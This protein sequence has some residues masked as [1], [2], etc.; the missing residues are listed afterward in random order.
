MPQNDFRAVVRVDLGTLAHSEVLDAAFFDV[1]ADLLNRHF[2]QW[3]QGFLDFGNCHTRFIGYAR[4]TCKNFLYFCALFCFYL[5]TRQFMGNT[6]V[7][8]NKV[9]LEVRMS[10]K[11]GKTTAFRQWLEN[12]EQ[13]EFAE[14]R[15]LNKS[16]A[17]NRALRRS[18]RDVIREMLTERKEEAEKALTALVP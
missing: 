15:N 11:L 7:V 14:G 3:T 10:K 9:Q 16:E 4:I 12:Q 17:I 2:L 1:N 18:L 13:L 8:V 5:S 6:L